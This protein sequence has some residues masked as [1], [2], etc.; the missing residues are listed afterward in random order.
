MLEDIAIDYSTYF[1]VDV[2]EGFKTVQ[3][4]VDNMLTRLEELTSV[5]QMVKLKNGDCCNIVTEDIIKY[6]RE[7][8][9]LGKRIS[10][11][12]NVLMFL[13]NNVDTV[14]K[15]VERAEGFFGVQNDNKLKSLLKPFIKRGRETIP[16]NSLPPHH[17]IDLSSVMDNFQ[18]M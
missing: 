11:L 18:S 4:V 7:I 2:L 12:S 3:D 16:D 17:K 13:S 1:K 9:V 15:Q 5:L 10:T 8:N 14:E 6:R